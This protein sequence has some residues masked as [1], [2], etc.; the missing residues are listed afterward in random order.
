[1]KDSPK[2]KDNSKAS[3]KD[4]AKVSSK[5]NSKDS[6]T[7]NPLAIAVFT[8]DTVEDILAQRGSA[9]WVVNP[10]K[11][12]QCKYLVCC[13]K[14]SWKNRK[15][16]VPAGAAFLIGIVSGLQ[17][18]TDSENDRGQSRFVI[19]ISD[20]ALLNKPGVWNKEARNPVAYQT[21][22]EL[23]IDLKGLKFKPLP[24]TQG[25]T[26]KGMTI[27][28]AKKALALSF[29]VRPEDVEITIRG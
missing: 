28:E 20:Y 21:L 12:G 14:E 19:E 6:P 4:N 18:R 11:A 1:M 3:S 17:K 13:K 25:L 7:D 15:T 23:G 8:A 26:G 24:S 5:E 29:G 9:G 16:G 2:S 10:A 27:A 22:G